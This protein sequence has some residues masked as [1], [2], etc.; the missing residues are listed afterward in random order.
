M[1]HK[2]TTM[3]AIIFSKNGLRLA[4]A[5]FLCLMLSCGGSD[6]GPGGGGSLPDWGIRSFLY[7]DENTHSLF[8]YGTLDEASANI[9]RGIIYSRME[10]PTLEN[11]ETGII[12]THD[13]VNREFTSRLE[14]LSPNATYYF[15]AYTQTGQ[16]TEY[17]EIFILQT[18]SLR[19]QCGLTS[20]ISFSFSGSANTT[21]RNHFYDE[22]GRLVLIDISSVTSPG[23]FSRRS[24]ILYRYEGESVFEVSIRSEE[25][26]Q[27][28]QAGVLRDG[29]PHQ[30]FVA[31]ANYHWDFHYPDSETITRTKVLD[32]GGVRNIALADSVTYHLNAEGNVEF[33]RDYHLNTNGYAAG[34]EYRYSFHEYRN[35]YEGNIVRALETGFFNRNFVTRID[36]KTSSA[37]DFEV[38]QQFNLDNGS[39]PNLIRYTLGP[40]HTFAFSACD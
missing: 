7:Q 19:Q 40:S 12:L 15:R 30:W 4:A 18:P 10:E 26:I 38:F 24:M 35:P 31:D 3:P 27:E 20:Y 25:P 36:K 9:N 16:V 34:N 32:E 1:R 5:T 11:S 23:A 28:R 37:S 21:T 22:Q 29:K 33:S 2:G 8:L 6:D 14:G 13:R 17:G 39:N